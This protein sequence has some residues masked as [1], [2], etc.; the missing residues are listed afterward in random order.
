MIEIKQYVIILSYLTLIREPIVKYFF[1]ELVLSQEIHSK[2]GVF[3]LQH[4]SQQFILTDS[5]L[6]IRLYSCAQLMLPPSTMLGTSILRSHYW[7][8][9]EYSLIISWFSKTLNCR[10]ENQ[11]QYY[12]VMYHPMYSKILLS[13]QLIHLLKLKYHG[14]GDSM[15]FLSLQHNADEIC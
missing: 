6:S 7:S 3:N 14:Y 15:Q 12:P 11:Y 2:I 10:S 5:L 1:A 8:S 4:Q 9:H 13:D